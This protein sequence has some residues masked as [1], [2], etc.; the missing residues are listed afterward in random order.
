M[1]GHGQGCGAVNVQGGRAEVLLHHAFKQIGPFPVQGHGE[2]AVGGREE[3]R[4][5]QAGLVLE[6]QELYGLVGLGPHRLAGDG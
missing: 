3:G 6:G 4:L 5:H 1:T 2:T